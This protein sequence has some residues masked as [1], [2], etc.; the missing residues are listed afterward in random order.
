MKRL[1][2]FYYHFN[3]NKGEQNK[4][5]PVII[6]RYQVFQ[7]YAYQPTDNRKCS[8]KKSQKKGHITCLLKPDLALHDA[9]LDGNGKAVK[10]QANP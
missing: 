7:G 5:D 6:G 10:T 8:L 3:T 4:G 2:A 1:H 9:K